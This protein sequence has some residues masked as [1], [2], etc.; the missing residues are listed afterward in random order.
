MSKCGGDNSHLA[1]SIN[2][3]GDS[4]EEVAEFVERML[5]E[6]M[7]TVGLCAMSEVCLSG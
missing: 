6:P 5:K 4:E 1:G 7:L 3:M 2:F